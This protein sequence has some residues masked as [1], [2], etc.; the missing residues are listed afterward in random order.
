MSHTDT[1]RRPADIQAGSIPYLLM[2]SR[3]AS[4][5]GGE[6]PDHN[7]ASSSKYASMAG[8]CS[9]SSRA[10][11]DPRFPNVCPA[12]RGTSRK[13]PGPP[14]SSA[15][16]SQNVTTPES[17]KN[18]SEQFTCRCA[19]GVLAPGGTVRS[20]SEKSPPVWAA[21]ALKAS[22]FPRA[23]SRC[24]CPDGTIGVMLPILARVGVREKAESDLLA[25][26]VAAL[27]DA[28]P[29]EFM[30]RRQQ[31][32]DAAKEAGDK[33][34]AKQITGLRKPTRSA[35]VVN[36]LVHADPDVTIR[37][38][39]LSTELRA[40]APDAARIRELTTARARLVDELTRQAFTLAGDPS[41]PAG[42]REEVSATLDAAIADP[43]VAGRLGHLVRAE[44]W[45]G[46]GLDP[47]APPA[48]P[49]PAKPTKKPAPADAIAETER[50][51]REKIDIAE[52]A[53]VTATE[54]SQAASEAEQQ[55]EDTVRRL[56]AELEQA[57][58]QL[59][60]ARR[61]A[62]RAESQQRRANET[63][64]RLRQ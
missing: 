14:D 33:D 55:L 53:V 36:H 61:Q 10:G 59:A 54:A 44:R 57:R 5:E 37:L 58:Q 32:A 7:R 34:A 22:T 21:T 4:T 8:A 16:S 20:M 24:P 25:E 45:A 9:T 51:R 52:R 18:A 19:G 38:A 43:G 50:R 29:D 46:F 30:P 1:L 60:E 28:D 40:G 48:P 6:P 23:V 3:S 12:P 41:P 26:A 15:E 17:T 35:W 39:A 2:S 64:G 11:S 56:E 42:Q 13:S 47:D 62:Y 49:A 31:L 63:L 27:Y